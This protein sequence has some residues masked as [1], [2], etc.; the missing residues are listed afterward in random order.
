MN[1]SAI[2]TKENENLS[3]CK[4]YYK[5]KRNITNYSN[6]LLQKEIS[7]EAFILKNIVHDN[8]MNLTF[9]NNNNKLIH[10]KSSQNFHIQNKHFIEKPLL[11]LPPVIK[12]QKLTK[13]M[14]MQHFQRTP[15]DLNSKILLNNKKQEFVT[16]IDIYIKELLKKKCLD[17]SKQ[18]KLS[19]KKEK[20]IQ[21][22]PKL[23][24]K[25]VNTRQ[26]TTELNVDRESESEKELN[27]TAISQLI[28]SPVIQY[29]FCE[30][31][32]NNITHRIQF[33]NLKNEEIS[34]KDVINIINYEIGAYLDE[35]KNKKNNKIH[36]FFTTGYE[37][38]PKQYFSPHS[39][40]SNYEE[41]I[42][43]QKKCKNLLKNINKL[44]LNRAYSIDDLLSKENGIKE[45]L[46]QNRNKETLLQLLSRNHNFRKFNIL[47]SL[48]TKP[49]KEC[50]NPKKEKTISIN[51]HNNKPQSPSANIRSINI[52]NKNNFDGLIINDSKRAISELKKNLLSESN[53]KQEMSHLLKFLKGKPTSKDSKKMKETNKTHKT[54]D[55]SDSSKKTSEMLHLTSG[56][57]VQNTI[58]SNCKF[59]GFQKVNN[60]PSI[61]NKHQMKVNDKDSLNNDNISKRNQKRRINLMNSSNDFST[62]DTNYKVKP[63]V[64]KIYSK[65]K[66]IE[67]E[68]I[69]STNNSVRNRVKSQEPIDQHQ[70]KI[71]EEE[72][73][74]QLSQEHKIIDQSPTHLKSNSS[75]FRKPKISLSRKINVKKKK[76]KKKTEHKIIEPEEKIESLI[77]E[78]QLLAS[79]TGGKETMSS[80]EDNDIWNQ[81]VERA[82]K[83]KKKG[84]NKKNNI[85]DSKRSSSIILKFPENLKKEETNQSQKES[86]ESI[87]K[88]RKS[89]KEDNSQLVMALKGKKASKFRRRNA[90]SN[91]QISF[92]FNKKM[93]N[94]SDSKPN[95]SRKRLKLK[96]KNENSSNKSLFFDV[97]PEEVEKKKNF[98]LLKLGQEISYG[99]TK[100]DFSEKEQNLFED[101]K[102]KIED[103]KNF[104]D[105]TYIMFLEHNF[106][107]FH[108]ELE[109]LRQIREDEKRINDFIV[110]L[111]ND[112]EVDSTI[113]KE[114]S[115][116]AKVIDKKVIVD[117]SRPFVLNLPKMIN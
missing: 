21:N 13:S 8:F 4:K 53:Q 98:L 109:T 27:K 25:A 9:K 17:I 41:I 29:K 90:L 105:K 89:L 101:F 51:S 87:Q 52:N 50:S 110:H 19:K 111:H 14:S 71:E 31:I 47:N 70:K 106:S 10:T 79:T 94:N 36:N 5:P 38:N 65:K 115:S 88:E 43:C 117:S 3:I 45:L 7:G 2:G 34:E 18:A 72:R 85:V 69:L 74:K 26:T 46:N 75:S 57:N 37:I 59:S 77:G 91:N 99:I 20:L 67:P 40:V 63:V 81:L 61:L 104:D 32:L 62:F 56:S 42:D 116:K 22:I 58:K 102:K 24:E 15:I 97:K 68:N 35:T 16:Q 86:E 92:F 93:N 49:K 95:S 33:L 44:S 28:N 114:Q 82:K 12:N 66:Y 108:E 1:I 55:P 113:K 84:N 64:N 39:L 11:S 78:Q 103:L 76:K 30:N 100:G 112:I 83:R 54:E 23:I 80:K 107:Y 48:E 60:A 73:K 96:E 6:S